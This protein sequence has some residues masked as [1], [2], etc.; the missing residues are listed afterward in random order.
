MKKILV[1]TCVFFSSIFLIKCN[2]GQEIL[3]NEVSTNQ[4][5]IN[6]IKKLSYVN[7]VEIMY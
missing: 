1:F 5:L 3:I 4:N 7:F 6:E 2:L